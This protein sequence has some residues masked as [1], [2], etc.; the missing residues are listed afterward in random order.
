ML[1]YVE[2]WPFFAPPIAAYFSEAATVFHIISIVP[3]NN[4][5]MNYSWKQKV[6]EYSL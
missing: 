5:A 1:D 3:V 4:T 6:L 2:M